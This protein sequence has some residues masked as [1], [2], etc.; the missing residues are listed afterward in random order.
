MHSLRLF[1]KCVPMT[2]AY[3]ANFQ[4]PLFGWRVPF[5]FLITPMRFISSHLYCIFCTIHILITYLLID[6]GFFSIRRAVEN[7]NSICDKLLI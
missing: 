6:Y 3:I 7:R 4:Q 5:D 2:T 1:I